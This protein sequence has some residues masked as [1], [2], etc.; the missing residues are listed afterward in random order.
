M[1]RA[2]GFTLIELVLALTILGTMLL[3]LYSG[4][5]FALR[6]WDAGDVNGRLTVDRRIG[7]NFLRR[8]VSELFP[9]RWKDP[10]TLK[11]AFEGDTDHL[12]FVSARP[13]GIATG[14]LSLVAI[15]VE[16]DPKNQR[17]HNLVMR[18]A[19]PDDAQKDFAP[20]EKAESSILIPEVDS[21][22]FSYFGAE[23]D[24]AEP[25]WTDSWKFQNRIPLMIR[26]RVKT[27]DGTSLPEMVMKVMLGE[28]AGC[29][30]NSF[31]RLC[32]PRRQ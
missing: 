30:E 31:Q 5:S 7:A 22:A 27:T 14:G 4:L 32:R 12:R 3:L 21:V 9:M 28:E 17:L 10:T 15:N 23:N 16:A 19:M 26:L 2:Q 25:A 20:V 13:A 1:R 6:S 11:L 24:F 8:E 29:L 18:R